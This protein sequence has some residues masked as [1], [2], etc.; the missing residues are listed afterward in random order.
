MVQSMATV[1]SE[2]P[3]LAVRP[4]EDKMGWYVEA[5][6]TNRPSENIGRFVTQSEARN[7]ITFESTSYFVLRESFLGAPPG[8]H[9]EGVNWSGRRSL[10]IDIMAT[11][12]MK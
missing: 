4:R 3:L 1:K 10:K 8:R 6:W 2:H 9:F 5:W 12:R 11:M 7:W